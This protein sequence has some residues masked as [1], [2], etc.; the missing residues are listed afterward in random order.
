MRSTVQ[1]G[2]RVHL[3]DTVQASTV[4]PVRSRSTSR[5]I[6][7]SLF[8]INPQICCTSPESTLKIVAATASSPRLALPRHRSSRPHT[9]TLRASARDARAT[10][11]AM[12]TTADRS[13]AS[14]SRASPARALLD[15]P[16]PARARP[17]SR[18][19]PPRARRVRDIVVRVENRRVHAR[20]RKNGAL[21]NALKARGVRCLASGGGGAGGLRRGVAGCFDERAV[22]LGVRDEPRGGQGVCEGTRRREGR[23]ECEWRWWGRRRTPAMGERYRI[24]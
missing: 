21:M 15:A 5:F 16:F 11:T 14:P 2:E 22:G 1:V 18:A 19:R 17:E 4:S 12:S 6:P 9:P 24:L 20:G 23:K 13:L 8:P 10:P 7:T 3:R